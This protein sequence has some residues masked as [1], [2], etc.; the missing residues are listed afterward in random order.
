MLANFTHC[1]A[2]ATKFLKLNYLF[3]LLSKLAL[4]HSVQAIQES[5]NSES[6]FLRQMVENSGYCFQFICWTCG[7]CEIRCSSYKA[8]S[9]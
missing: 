1:C 5:R 9:S 2:S 7:N 3:L 8:L 4:P 6:I